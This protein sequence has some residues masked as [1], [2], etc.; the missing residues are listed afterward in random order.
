MNEVYLLI[1]GLVVGL[2]VGVVGILNYHV[3]K[4]EEIARDLGGE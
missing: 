1:A 4:L 3:K 2:C